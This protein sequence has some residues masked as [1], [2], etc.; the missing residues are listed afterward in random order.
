MLLVCSLSSLEMQQVDWTQ[1][2]YEV[3]FV[4]KIEDILDLTFQDG[5]VLTI[6][7]FFYSAEN[8]LSCFSCMRTLPSH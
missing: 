7:K 3:N 1:K 4:D 5:S 6:G 8:Y 2:K